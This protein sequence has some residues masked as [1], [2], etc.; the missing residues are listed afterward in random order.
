MKIMNTCSIFAWPVADM[1]SASDV[2][3]KTHNI[4][5]S[6]MLFLGGVYYWRATHCRL[7]QQKPKNKLKNQ[8]L[9]CS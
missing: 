3:I 6:K 1:S 8:F 4:Q 7:F 2:A 9:N 5:E